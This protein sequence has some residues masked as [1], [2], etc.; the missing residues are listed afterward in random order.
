MA[1]PADKKEATATNNN[2]ASALWPTRHFATSAQH[3]FC[4]EPSCVEKPFKTTILLAFLSFYAPVGY[5]A[6]ARV[7]GTPK[8]FVTPHTEI[9]LFLAWL[10]GKVRC[11]RPERLRQ[12]YLPNAAWLLRKQTSLLR[13]LLLVHDESHEVRLDA[14][15][16]RPMDV[17][18]ILRLLFAQRCHA[19]L[20]LVLAVL[21]GET[22]VCHQAQEEGFTACDG[23]LP[24]KLHGLLHLRK[25][26]RGSHTLQDCLAVR[27]VL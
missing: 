20:G 25:L 8:S 5:W 16:Q 21:R 14:W 18:P 23:S 10:V 17:G 1:A 12:A 11:E 3:A 9:F 19:L 13:A 22:L 27:D 15:V 4:E 7:G 2:Q 26:G 6:S 24:C